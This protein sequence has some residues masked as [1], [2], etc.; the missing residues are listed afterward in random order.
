MFTST[1]DQPIGAQVYFPAQTGNPPGTRVFRLSRD[2]RDFIHTTTRCIHIWGLAASSVG[3]VCWHQCCGRGRPK[4][5]LSPQCVCMYVWLIADLPLANVATKAGQMAMEFTP[6]AFGLMGSKLKN[7]ERIIGQDIWQTFSWW[8]R[9]WK[10][11]GSIRWTV[12][13]FFL[14]YIHPPY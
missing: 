13:S 1:R 12:S 7:F 3:V 14:Q 6:N 10:M 9:A 4:R 11:I 5:I 8:H 2:P